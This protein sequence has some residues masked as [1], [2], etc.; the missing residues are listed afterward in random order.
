MISLNQRAEAIVRQMM[1]GCDAIGISVRRMKNGTTLLDAGI[2]MPGS[3]EAGRLF[4]EACLGGLGHVSFTRRTYHNRA[5]EGSGFWLPA[6]TVN[7]RTPHIACMASQYAGWQVKHEGYFAMGSGPGRALFAGE[8]IYQK[9]QYK[10]Q[11]E[12]AILML[13][14]RALP[15]EAVADYLSDKCGVKPDGLMLLVAP[16]AS[17]VGSV[18]IAARS[19]ETAMH[20]LTELGFDIRKVKTGS[21]LCPLAPV[22]SDDL[23][24]IG[25][26]NDF[27]LYGAQVSLAVQAEDDELKSLID[28]VP[29]E[30]S[31][32]YGTPFKELFQRCN[33][34][35]YQIDPMLFSPAQVEIDNLSSGRTFRAGSLNPSLLQAS[36][37]GG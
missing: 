26:T 33:G 20:K 2:E 22:A 8:A 28:R 5:G 6:V 36:L 1:E 17:P 12:T 7:I 10:D 21:G 14:T 4:S 31:R 16:T 24:A 35:F 27:I 34:D 23:N 3:L 9:L 15:T 11:A 29:S 19:V 18:Q 32:D 37:L 30:N 25:R 13:E